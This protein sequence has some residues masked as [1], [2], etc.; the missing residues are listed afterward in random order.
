MKKRRTNK[1]F[2][3]SIKSQD[4]HEKETYINEKETCTHEKETYAHQKETNEQ[5]LLTLYQV[6][7]HT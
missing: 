7:G 4:I 1:T 5:D 2:S 3:L 6:S